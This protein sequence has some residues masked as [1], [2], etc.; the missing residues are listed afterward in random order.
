M[1]E[2]RDSV[3]ACRNTTMLSASTPT[4]GYVSISQFSTYALLQ[5]VTF[6]VQCQ[7]K[8]KKKKLKTEQKET[9]IEMD[10]I[11][12]VSNK[13]PEELPPQSVRKTP[14]SSNLFHTP[15]GWIYTYSAS[16]GWIYTYWIYTYWID[17]PVSIKAGACSK[18]FSI[19][20]Y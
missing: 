19:D 1:I 3:Y 13:K 7:S 15:I 11:Q 9:K 8:K 5:L 2:K 12:N 18:L 20:W 10:P 16:I 6:V 4:V 14:Y 17:V